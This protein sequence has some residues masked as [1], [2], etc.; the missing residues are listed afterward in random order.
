MWFCYRG[1]HNFRDGEDAYRIGYA[2]SKDLQHWRR[3]D[4]TVGIDI[5]ETGWD[6]KMIAYP[7]VVTVKGRTLM[8]YN[9]NGFGVD[10]FGY[11]ILAED[12]G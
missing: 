6:S 4:D 3:E 2:Q 5:S 8:F 9:G 11:A 7:A 10:G 12:G 1:S